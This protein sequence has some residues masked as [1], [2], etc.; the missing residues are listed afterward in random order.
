MVRQIVT[1]ITVA[2]KFCSAE[3]YHQKYL[4]KHP[5]GYTCHY[6]RSMKLGE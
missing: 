5:H 3:E 2:G 1:E 6:V 4:I